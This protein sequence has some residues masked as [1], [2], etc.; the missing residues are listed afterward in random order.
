MPPAF[1]DVGAPLV[2]FWIYCEF[3]V[4]LQELSFKHTKSPGRTAAPKGP[5]RLDY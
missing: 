5:K 4:K 1:V 3:E 2:H